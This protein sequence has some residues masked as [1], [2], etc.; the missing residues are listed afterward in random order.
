MR[1]TLLAVLL[2]VVAAIAVAQQQQPY[3]ETFEVRLHNLDVVVTDRQGKPVSGLTR[4][5]FEILENGTPREITN[6]SVYD[7]THAATGFSPSSATKPRA[8]ARATL[9]RKF[10][11]FMDELVL[12]PASRKKLLNNA[13][14]LLRNSMQPGD[15]ATVIRP[16]GDW[17]VRLPFTSDLK[18]IEQSLREV[19]EESNTRTNTRMAAEVVFLDNQLATSSTVQEKHYAIRLYGEIARRRVEQ[20]LG[21]L[22]AVIG[23]LSGIEGKKVLVLATASLAAQPGREAINLSDYRFENNPVIDPENAAVLP[24]NMPDLQ[25]R[26]DDLG[27]IAGANGV[28]IYALQPDVPLQLAAGRGVGDSTTPAG[29]TRR[30]LSNIDPRT[31]RPQRPQHTLSYRTELIVAAG[32]TRI[33]VGVLDEASKL[34]G[35]STIEVQA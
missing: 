18:A 6:F 24:K 34:S 12:H 31:S 14:T 21:Q 33:A 7:S 29:T 23:S 28:T 32:R 19:L 2:L 26:I 5:D 10:V 1:R 9:P 25:P 3:I 30:D 13:M 22:L 17:N 20:R 27:R 15:E 35:F 4:D 8:E 16:F 11:F